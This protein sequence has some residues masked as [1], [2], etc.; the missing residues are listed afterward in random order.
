M[1]ADGG[2]QLCIGRFQVQSRDRNQRLARRLLSRWRVG[3]RPLGRSYRGRRSSVRPTQGRRVNLHGSGKGLAGARRAARSRRRGGKLGLHERLYSGNYL[4]FCS[5]N[6][7]PRADHETEK[8]A[9]I[10]IKERI[11]EIAMELRTG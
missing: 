10:R 8:V 6:K 3:S 11:D 4:P 2:L 7:G 5:Y 1:V 9:T